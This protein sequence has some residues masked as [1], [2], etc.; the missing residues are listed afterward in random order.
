[1]I[2]S[3]S[4]QKRAESVKILNVRRIDTISA[5][6]PVFEVD[7]INDRGEMRENITIIPSVLF[8]STKD[9]QYRHDKGVVGKYTRALAMENDE[10]RE[11]VITAIREFRDS[12]QDQMRDLRDKDSHLL[13]AQADLKGL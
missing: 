2:A 6:H 5:E 8:E 13:H 9:V 1:M 10:V 4:R 3:T 7:L 11:L 12:T